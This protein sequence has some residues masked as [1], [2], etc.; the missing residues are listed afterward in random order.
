MSGAAWEAIVVGAGPA[1]ALAAAMIA[2]TG[3]RTL[4][5]ERGA[6]PR[7]K[8]C[9]C[10]LAP[11]G[12]AVLERAGL[13]G[14]LD[15][16]L[17]AGRLDVH[18]GGRH[19]GVRV[20]GYKVIGRSPMDERLVREAVASG[21][22]FRDGVRA[23]AH[24]D[25][26][27][28][29]TV[30]GERQ[31]FRVLVVADGLSGQT[32]RGWSCFGWRVQRGSR[33]GVGGVVPAGALARPDGRAQ[34]PAAGGSAITMGVTRE[35]YTGVA[36]LPTGELVVASALDPRAVRERGPA[37]VASEVFESSG[38][39]ELDLSG[40]TLRG[41][42][43]GALR[44][45][46]ELTR[47]RASVEAGGRV[48]LVGDACGYVEPFTGE[49]MSWALE[50][51]ERVSL[52]ASAALAGKYEAGAWTRDV[53]AHARRAKLGCRAVR[54]AVRRPALTGALIEVGRALPSAAALGARAIVGLRG[55][56]A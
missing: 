21:A 51:A 54:W 9:G 15:G 32:L 23:E 33:I 41:R 39:G 35:G 42:L 44:G 53:R 7:H 50:G 47:T 18:A 24:E 38:A 6:F 8:V 4:L 12:Q 37:R 2:R 20:P 3:A 29:V 40:D 22:E 31:S 56:R 55:A 45:V 25:E 10:C 19:L 5:V 26:L 36:P 46:P 1:G 13:A 43:R 11:K 16:A 28:V 27:G 30:D 14:V 17:Y 34:G 52:H 49:G 48:F